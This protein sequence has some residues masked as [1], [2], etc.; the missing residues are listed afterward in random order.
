MQAE[1]FHRK[2][3]SVFKS[4]NFNDPKKKVTTDSSG[5]A[6]EIKGNYP[7]TLPNLHVV[8]QENNYIKNL[9]KSRSNTSI[10]YD[11]RSM[12]SNIGSV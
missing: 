9:K 5:K 11:K 2:H 12:S 7:E 4:L 6:I 10:G 8:V 1:E 3:P